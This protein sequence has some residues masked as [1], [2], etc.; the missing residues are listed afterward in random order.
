MGTDYVFVVMK[1]LRCTEK[2]CWHDEHFAVDRVCADQ[3]LADKACLK[4]PGA[5]WV[6]KYVYFV[7]DSA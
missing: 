3:E 2:D 5:F 1:P 4:I 7:G 6:P